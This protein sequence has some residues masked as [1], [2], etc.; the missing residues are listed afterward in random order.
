MSKQKKLHP[1]QIKLLERITPMLKR[2]GSMTPRQFAKAFGYEDYATGSFSQQ[3]VRLSEAGVLHCEEVL[4][5][6][7]RLRERR[8]SLPSVKRPT[9]AAI[10]PR[11]AP[12]QHTPNSPDQLP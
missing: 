3:F 6:S 4:S 5:K 9:S 7:G 8:F 2:N 1:S 11:P 12:P 10:Q